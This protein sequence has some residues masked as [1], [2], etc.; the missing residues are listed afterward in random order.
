MQTI[1]PLAILKRVQLI[2]LIHLR[3]A[4]VNPASTATVRERAL[5]NEGQYHTIMIRSY[6]DY[7]LHKI[8]E[9]NNNT[10][11]FLLV[12]VFLIQYCQINAS[13]H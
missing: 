7:F 1:V 4:K 5:T 8:L 6:T 11:Y 9:N 3:C 12:N 2:Y 10:D 13:R